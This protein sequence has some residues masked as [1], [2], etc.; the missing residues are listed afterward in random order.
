MISCTDNKKRVSIE[1]ERN[2]GSF[3]L[4]MDHLTMNGISY[5]IPAEYIDKVDQLLD[6]DLYE[7]IWD[8][9][10]SFL[11]GTQDG[12]TRSEYHFYDGNVDKKIVVNCCRV[13]ELE[14]V[15]NLIKEISKSLDI[16]VSRWLGYDKFP[17]KS[18]EYGYVINKRLD[19]DYPKDLL[20]YDNELWLYRDGNLSEKIIIRS[21]E[22]IIRN[23]NRQKKS[24]SY[25]EQQLKVASQLLN[26]MYWERFK[27]WYA[28]NKGGS[29]GIKCK[30]RVEIRT[31]I[32]GKI[33]WRYLRSIDSPSDI[34]DELENFISD[35]K[36]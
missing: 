26:K 3:S 13:D 9:N 32:N 20:R 4:S 10:S 6:L 34:M 2:V 5:D 18:E 27:K 19:E 25:S 30:E 36:S 16:E 17:L 11:C 12:A 8:Y 22:M 1:I 35:V 31:I 14:K 15:N 23:S 21:E 24:Y 28:E 33:D 29:C 7:N